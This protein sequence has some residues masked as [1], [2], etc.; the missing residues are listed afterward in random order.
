MVLA[1]SL[2]LLVTAGNVATPL[3][4]VVRRVGEL[5]VEVEVNC[6][7]GRIPAGE[8]AWT[9]ESR[10]TELFH[11]G[12]IVDVQPLRRADLDDVQLY[13]RRLATP[14]P[15]SRG[16]KLTPAPDFKVMAD[17]DALTVRARA[18]VS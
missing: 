11:V 10:G 2:S 16:E 18:A 17:C 15:K 7:P 13:S 8:L 6:K 14:A 9:K 1:L 12:E 5:D 3:K 4:A